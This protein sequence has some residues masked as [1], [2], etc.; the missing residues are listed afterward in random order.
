MYSYASLKEYFEVNF[1]DLLQNKLKK[2]IDENLDGNGFHEFNVY[3]LAKYEIDNFEIK[4]I[5][6]FDQPYDLIKIRIIV[7]ADVIQ[8][9]LGTSRYEADRRNHWFTIDA[10][11]DLGKHLSDLSIVR[12]EEYYDRTVDKDT[13]LDQ[14]LLP[15]YYSEDLE[16]I[17]EDFYLLVPEGL[18]KYRFPINEFMKEHG[19]NFHY[20]ELPDNCFGRFYFRSSTEGILVTNKNYTSFKIKEKRIEANT[21]LINSDKYFWNTF[22]NKTLTVIHELVHWYAHRKYILLLSLLNENESNMSCEIEPSNFNKNMSSFQKAHWFAEWQANALAIRIAM[23]QE[24]MKYAMAEAKAIIQRKGYS[25]TSDIVEGIIKEVANIFDVSFT[26]AKQRMRQLGWDLPDG[27]FVYV[28]NYHYDSFSFEEGILGPRETFIIDKKGYEK[29]YKSS[30]NFRELI[31]NGKY[32]YL[33]YVTCVNDPKYIK[34]EFL[35]NEVKLV[36]SNYAKEHA[37]E[38]CLI[39]SLQSNS[40]LQEQGVEYNDGYLNKEV[41]ADSYVEYSYDK[42]FN[43]K[44]LQSSEEIK[45]V[46]D[47]FT[48]EVSKEN[49]VM[50]DMI[51][52]GCN[53]FGDTLTFHM[54]RKNINVDELAERSGLSDTTIKK[55]RS[56][57]TSNP[58]IE[59]VMAICIGL[60]LKKSYANDMLSKCSYSLNNSSRD[61]AYRFLLENHTDGTLEQWNMILDA[62]KQPHIPN[63]KGQ[64]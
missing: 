5:R 22:G 44:S 49:T 54:D 20:A 28:D 19:I 53:S 35:D 59:N 56:G 39:Y 17:A 64:N 37:E 50:K 43:L 29:L 40:Y 7:S 60:N 41:S 48:E 16:N 11:G 61:L 18:H 1:E 45:S 26:A 21:I 6:C 63:K 14:F 57:K 58:P 47:K 25:R 10:K 23:P 42:N 3:S 8:L 24:K 55:Y 62:F 32:L 2:Y 38:C 12:I 27:T 13:A 33:G 9:G 15:Y 30:S 36:L 46:I 31:D 4:S 51:V 52:N 34:A